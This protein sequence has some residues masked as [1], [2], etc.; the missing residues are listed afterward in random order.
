MWAARRIVDPLSHDSVKDK[1][2]RKRNIK[3][4]TEVINHHIDEYHHYNNSNLIILDCIIER[5]T[6]SDL[7]ASIVDGRYSEQKHR[8]SESK[9]RTKIY[10]I[11]AL[12]LSLGSRSGH[13]GVSTKSLET[14]MITT[15]VSH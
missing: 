15:Q 2:N 4:T 11:E 13:R 1:K 7:A 3:A 6:S 14:A 9:F 10:I 8:L 5:K 12:T